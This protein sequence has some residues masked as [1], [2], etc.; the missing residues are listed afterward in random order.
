MSRV[1]G[2]GRHLIKVGHWLLVLEFFDDISYRLQS[3]SSP[4]CCGMILQSEWGG[5]KY[6][7]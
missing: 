3:A 1:A 7:E 4:T 2:V 6:D 5:V